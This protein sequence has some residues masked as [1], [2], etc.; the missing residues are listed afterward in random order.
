MS[1]AF[2]WNLPV[3]DGYMDESPYA[4][5]RDPASNIAERLLMLLHLGFNM[6][7]WGAASGRMERYWPAFGEHVE[8]AI[9]SP[10]VPAWWQKASTGLVTVPI[11]NLAVVHEKNILCR[12]TTLPETAVPDDEVLQVL[13]AHSLDLRDRTR[14]WNSTRPKKPRGTPDTN[15]DDDL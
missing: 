4:P 15:G 9:D 3:T 12:P 2:G 1:N 6:R 8:A 14:V 11:K 7:V 5:L 13:H 10:D